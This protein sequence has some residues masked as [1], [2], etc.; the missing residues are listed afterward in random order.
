MV[1]LFQGAGLD[2]EFTP[3]RACECMG[4]CLTPEGKDPCYFPVWTYDYMLTA[5]R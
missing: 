5:H 3:E 4:C 1:E 2:G